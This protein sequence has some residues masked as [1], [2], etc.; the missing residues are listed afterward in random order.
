M[1]YAALWFVALSCREARPPAVTDDAGP[2]WALSVD[3]PFAELEL[4][5][6]NRPDHRPPPE[7]I[8][9]EGPWN[10][11][12]STDATR[13]Y[14]APLPVR[15]RALFFFKPPTGMKLVNAQG[16]AL[17]Y[18]D[19]HP[20][21]WKFSAESLRYTVAAQAPAPA[22]GELV[23]TYPYATEREARLN[24]R[25]SGLTPEA[26]ARARVQ[27]GPES[28]GGL[29]L[30]APAT[31]AFAITVPPSAELTFA[32][33]LVEP[34]T[35][36]APASDGATLTVQVDADG[37]VTDVWTGRLES[38]DFDTV[39]VDLSPWSGRTVK[40]RFRTD[41]GADPT[42]DYAFVAD[43]IVAARKAAPKR[44]VMIFVD[45]LRADHL[46]LYGY[47]RDTSAPFD[48]WAQGATVFET[49]LSTAPWTLPSTRAIL[50]GRAPEVWDEAGT[51]QAALRARGWATGM[52]AGNVYLSSNF[53][54]DR[55]WGL[56]H[57]VNWPDAEDQVDRALE[58]LDDTDGRDALLLVHF[59]DAHLPYSE[60]LTYRRRYAGPGPNA[61]EERFERGDVVKLNPKDPKV[62][63]Y[64]RDRYDNNIAYVHDEIGRL[65]RHVGDDAIVVYFSDHGEEFWDHGGFEHGH[66][67]YQELIR[68]PF[69][70]RVPGVVPSRVPEPVTTMDVTPTVLDALGVSAEGLDGRSLLPAMRG[71]P[72]ARESLLTRDLA[73]GRP[74]YGMER[75]GVLHRGAQKYTTHEGKEALFDLSRDPGEETNLLAD[76]PGPGGAPWRERL[77]DAL[78]RPVHVGFRVTA[79]SVRTRPS[80]DLIVDVHVPGGVAAAWVGDDPTDKSSAA[81]EIDGDVATATIH[82]GY[83]GAAEIFVIPT[84]PLEAVPPG[85]ELRVRKADGSVEVAG[86]DPTREPGLG[87]QRGPLA[88]VRVEN[89]AVTLT[90]AISPARAGVS[91]SGTDA[92][93]QSALE[94][95]GYA[96]GD[97]DK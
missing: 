11:I 58:W 93:M 91:L 55:D 74:L 46:G 38:A 21:T 14:E 71:E 12:A 9:V 85:V 33:G 13:T 88:R 68:V 4:P 49:A 29:L 75:W 86:V 16:R 1:L 34:E 20:N 39:R 54:M 2:V 37:T 73:F 61:L 7:T 19:D 65:L 6:D 76:D 26:F 97:D 80:R 64:I 53:D 3:V 41:P 66:T 45:T 69:V 60:P 42:F 40:L 51:L 57:V 96:V 95:L 84:Q 31:A 94:A 52:F 10:L 77:G 36:D 63:Q 17:A 35:A 23:L 56:H 30:P 72:A 25:F 59:M 22:P 24:L 70:I 62:R 15:P 32:P 82:A 78:E 44:V 28:R 8:A 18:G 83:A 67:L 50:T 47:A 92:E 89:R 48:A 81:V 90:V 79:G 87:T 5:P 27:A 43:P